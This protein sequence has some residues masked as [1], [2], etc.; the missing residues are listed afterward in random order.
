MDFAF[1]GI[2]N[3]QPYERD[4]PECPQTL[5]VS[6]ETFETLIRRLITKY[7]DNVEHVVGN[8]VGYQRGQDN[9]LA[10]VRYHST[11]GGEQVLPAGFV[12]G[13][14]IRDVIT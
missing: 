6:R 5:C 3:Q 8:I 14:Y 4:D 13:T 2:I 9:R 11:D 12:V 7:C 1:G 10:G